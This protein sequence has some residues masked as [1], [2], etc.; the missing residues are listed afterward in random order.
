MAS[1]SDAKTSKNGLQFAAW[2]GLVPRQKSSGGKE[3]LLGISKR[4]DSYLRTSLI[5]GARAAVRHLEPSIGE[6]QSWL[7]RVANRC[8]PNIAAVALANKNA[9]IVWAM[10]AHDRDR[11]TKP[12][13]SAH[14]PR[15]FGMTVSSKTGD[16]VSGTVFSLTMIAQAFSKV[17][18]S[19]V[20]PG[21]APQPT[22]RQRWPG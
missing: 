22:R 4:G 15:R 9:R 11:I 14:A 3:R 21:L 20:R 7:A 17:M 6:P 12:R 19:Q 5:H 10:L 18:A 2:L 8:N 16:V 1:L 13:M